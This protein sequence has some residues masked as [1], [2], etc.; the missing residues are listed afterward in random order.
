MCQN[1]P[2]FFSLIMNLDYFE[3][4]NRTSLDEKKIEFLS[5]KVNS[6]QFELHSICHHVL[7]TN[8]VNIF[9]DL[10]SFYG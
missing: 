1:Y 3:D 8:K 10:L 5:S 6:P 7:I 2:F 9:P 4:L